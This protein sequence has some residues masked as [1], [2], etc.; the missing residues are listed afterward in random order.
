V[1]VYVDGE[2]NGFGRMVMCHMFADT[3]AELHAMADAIG[4]RRA[5]FQ[6]LSFPHYDV[7]LGRRARAVA[8][9]A[10]EVFR[11]EGYDHRKRIRA[12]MSEADIAEIRAWIIDLAL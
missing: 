8:L 9:G 5:W 6:P 12:A 4:M 10:V 2:R 3:L 7:A 1:A 11:R